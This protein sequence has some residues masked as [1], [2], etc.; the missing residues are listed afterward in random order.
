MGVLGFIRESIEESMLR[1]CANTLLSYDHPFRNK[2][3]VSGVA[4][5]SESHISVYAWPERSFA[6]IDVFRCGN[7]DPQTTIN[8]L[9]KTFK[10]SSIDQSLNRR[11][12]IS[13]V[14]QIYS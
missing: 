11:G 1:T 8:Y 13:S 14:A 3:C 12:V 4:V 7:C 5:L 10:P 2:M 6:S 9:Q